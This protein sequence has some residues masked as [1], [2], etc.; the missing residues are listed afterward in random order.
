[1]FLP[2]EPPEDLDL[3][4]EQTGQLADDGI[5]LRPLRADRFDVARS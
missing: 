5:V 3:G 1:M 4:R 2:F